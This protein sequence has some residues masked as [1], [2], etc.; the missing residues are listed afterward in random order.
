MLQINNNNNNNNNTTMVFAVLSSM[1]E[2]YAKVHSGH[3]RESCSAP[4][5]R[6][7]VG[8]AA[9][10]TFESTSTGQTFTHRYL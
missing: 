8:Q 2:A 3:L 7:L 5:G 9:N 4:G 6:Q 1:A 10:L